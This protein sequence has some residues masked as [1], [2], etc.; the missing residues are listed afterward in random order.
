MFHPEVF[1]INRLLLEVMAAQVDLVV[2]AVLVVPVV[3]VIT[4]DLYAEH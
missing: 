4:V 3:L 1:R 2:L